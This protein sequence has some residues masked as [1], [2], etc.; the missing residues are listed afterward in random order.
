M[1]YMKDGSHH[2]HNYEHDIHSLTALTRAAG[3]ET[4]VLKTVDVFEAAEPRGRRALDRLGMPT[5]FRGD[6]IVY[7]GRKTGSVADRWPASVYV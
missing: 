3:F 7:V 5:E 2:R 1:Q 6:D 4:R